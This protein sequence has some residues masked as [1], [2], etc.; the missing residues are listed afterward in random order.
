MTALIEAKHVSKAFGGG[1]FD[2]NT[3]LAL[4]DFSLAIQSE[5]ASITAVVGESGSGKTTLARVLL[6]LALPT[7]GSV[8][9]RGKDLT[10]M[11]RAEWRE[12]RREV[13]A[14]GQ[15]I[16]ETW[17]HPLALGQSLPTLPL[18]LAENLAVPLELEQSYEETCRILRI[19]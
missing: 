11:G 7:K 6:G 3:T 2:R 12:F 19:R 13:E 10:R 4:E 18:W 9:Y 5:P 8:F 17:V 15:E 1:L 14:R 16:L